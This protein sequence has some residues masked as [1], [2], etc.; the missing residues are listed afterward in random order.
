MKI[1]TINENKLDYIDSLRGVAILMVILVH[2][3]QT[4]QG[5]SYLI[6][7]FAK[8][9]QMGVVLFFCLSAITQCMSLERTKLNKKDIKHF[10]IKRYFRIAP[11]YY[12]GIIFYSLL[13]VILNYYNPARAALHQQYTINNILANIFFVHG[14]YPSANNNIVPGGWS[15]GTE[16]LFYLIVPFVFLLYRK[17]INKI[18]YFIFPLIMLAFSLIFFYMGNYYFN[19]NVANNSFWYYNLINHLPVFIFAISY[20]FLFQNIEI[21]KL[22]K[23][24]LLFVFLILLIANIY[25]FVNHFSITLAPFLASIAFIV[26]IIIFKEFKRLNNKVLIKIGQLSYSMY[27]F[28][29]I[30]AFQLSKILLNKIQHFCSLNFTFLICYVSSI[31]FAFLAA[32]VSQN[33][34]EKKGIAF[35]KKFL[36]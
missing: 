1:N 34:I 16:M 22:F 35:G 14:I 32:I 7:S 6:S 33:V 3:A 19:F 20:Y 26:L 24:L 17:T 29:F 15:I 11:L 25:F 30:F 28:H 36:K 23:Y 4:V 5:T 12:T 13:T 2:T 27:I 9:G 8:F 21:N 10:Y 18:W 31:A